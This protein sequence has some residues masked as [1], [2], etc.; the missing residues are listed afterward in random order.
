MLL[1]SRSTT[2]LNKRADGQETSEFILNE[3]ELRIRSRNT[4][5]VRC[6]ELRRSIPYDLHDTLGEHTHTKTIVCGLIGEAH[7]AGS[8]LVNLGCGSHSHPIWMNIDIASPHPAVHEHNL[9]AGIPL[10][11][12]SCDAVH[13]H[14]LEHMPKH[15]AEPFIAECFR[16][17]KPGGVIRIAIPDLEQIPCYPTISIRPSRVTR[18]C[19]SLRL[20]DDG[21]DRPDDEKR[22]WGRDGALLAA[23]SNAC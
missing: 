12:E 8:V 9:M 21:A 10:P 7:D 13:S 4:V 6:G 11:D 15:Q 20:D 19:P 2:R 14:V 18:S 23:E 5:R 17:L 22:K 16:V 3:G 1:A